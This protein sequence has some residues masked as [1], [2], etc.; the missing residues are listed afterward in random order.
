MLFILF[1]VLRFQNFKNT[2][3]CETVIHLCYCVNLLS[4]Y[5]MFQEHVLVINDATTEEALKNDLGAVDF[6]ENFDNTVFND[7]NIVNRVSHFD[8]NFILVFLNSLETVNNFIE[9]VIVVLEVREERQLLKG[10]LDE[11]HVLVTVLIDTLFDVIEDFR[12]LVNNLVK[13][14]FLEHASHAVLRCDN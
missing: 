10:H 8:E 13:V 6:Q 4:I 14:I 3:F 1:D 9:D 12:V 2:L 11:A 7:V 5:F